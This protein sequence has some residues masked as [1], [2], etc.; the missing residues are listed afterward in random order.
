MKQRTL[1]VF[2]VDDFEN[3]EA[4][5][6]TKLPLVKNHFFMLKERNEKIENLLKEHD[7]SYFI[8]NDEGFTPKKETSKEIIKIIEKEKVVVKSCES[9]IYDKIVRSGEELNLDKNAVFLNRINAGAKITTSANIELYDEN[10]GLVI[11]DGEYLIVKKNI[12]G[13]IIFKGLDIGKVEKLTFFSE[14]VKK[15]LE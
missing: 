13:T 9:L 14:K 5:V 1:R 4:V 8:L 10:E 7:L 11:A 15:V 12:K 6:K 3:L 2:E